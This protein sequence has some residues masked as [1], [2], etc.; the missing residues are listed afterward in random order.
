MRHQGQ[1]PQDVENCLKAESES[2][3]DEGIITMKLLVFFKHGSQS[4]GYSLNTDPLVDL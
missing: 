2:H 4:A 1:V 3:R